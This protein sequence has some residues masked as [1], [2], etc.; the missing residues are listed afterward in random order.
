MK[1]PE[2][3]FRS[4]GTTPRILLIRLRSLGDVVLMTPVLKSIKQ[5]SPK[6]RL[7]VLVEYPFSEALYHHPCVDRLLEIR[8]EGGVEQ[9]PSEAAASDVIPATVATFSAKSRLLFF[10]RR[11]HYDLVWNLHGGTT[12]AWFTALSGG[13]LRIG[14]CQFRNHFAY[15]VLMPSTGELLGKSRHHTVEGTM[16]WFHWL[17]GESENG[18]ADIPPMDVVVDDRARERAKK[19]LETAGMDPR[20][21]YAVIQPAAVFH[22]KEWMPD[23]FAAVADFLSWRGFQ[24]V[25]TGGAHER[26]K[27]EKVKSLATGSV[28]ILANLSVREL[29]A[30]LEGSSLYVGND[31]GPGHVAA[32]L[33]KPTV[34]LFGSSNSVAWRPWQSGGVV[35]QN[36][37]D[38]NPCPGYRCLKYDEPECIKSITVDQ[39]K[40]AVEQILRSV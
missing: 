3:F 27:L 15:N 7:D 30:V 23:R 38:C 25:L 6:A 14:S 11:T 37:Y 12:S 17:R 28:G 13:R 9:R 8:T 2:D 40:A 19:K 26:T 18:A 21:R 29:M 32:A 33:K 36:P 20:C 10:I 16:A 5:V 35:V 39:V 31:S 22:T 34:V 24:V 4:V 1:K